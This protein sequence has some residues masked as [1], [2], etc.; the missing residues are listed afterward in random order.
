MPKTNKTALSIKKGTKFHNWTAIE[1]DS[2]KFDYVICE[3][4]CGNT[5]SVN[6]YSLLSGKSKSCGC[7]AIDFRRKTLSNHKTIT[8]AVYAEKDSNKT[9]TEDKKTS[10]KVLSKEIKEDDMNK[11]T[12]D[13]NDARIA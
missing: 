11:I 7:K 5:R 6:V 9:K 12:K 2:D 1:A 13:V 4:V 8:Y 3:C 10:R